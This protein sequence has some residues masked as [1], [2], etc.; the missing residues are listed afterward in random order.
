M[1]GKSGTSRSRDWI[2]SKI[3]VLHFL[4]HCIGMISKQNVATFSLALVL[5]AICFSPSLTS[6]KDEKLKPEDLVAKHLDSIGPAEK[7][8]AVKSRATS[9]ATQVVFR[10]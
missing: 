1:P 9:G 4:R 10:V 2:N 7:R 5:L 6:A 3:A 8:N